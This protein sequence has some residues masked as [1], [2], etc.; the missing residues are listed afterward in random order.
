M[1]GENLFL[2]EIISPVNA[3]RSRK[4][5]SVTLHAHHK[6]NFADNPDLRFDVDNGIT[7]CDKCHSPQN[8]GSF[9][10]IYG[11]WHNTTEQL[12]KYLKMRKEENIKEVM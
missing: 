12:E 9:H 6:E 5:K 1:I 11:T 4:G 8:E 7:L 2:R 3:E 10:Y